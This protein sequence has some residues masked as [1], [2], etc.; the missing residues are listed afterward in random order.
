[1]RTHLASA[2]LT[3]FL[4]TILVTG[5]AEDPA[6]LSPEPTDTTLSEDARVEEVLAEASRWEQFALESDGGAAS[7]VR[8]IAGASR[9]SIVVVPAGSV[10]ALAGALATAGTGGIVV[11]QSGMHTESGT[12]TINTRVHVIGEPGAILQIDTQPFP[13]A[14]FNDPA[15]HVLGAS[16]VLLWG[17]DLRP[18]QGSGN[19]GILLQNASLATIGHSKVT[20]FQ[21]GIVGY[22]SDRA[23][24]YGNVIRAAADG[25]YAVDIV[26]GARV[27]LVSNEIANGPFFGLWAC[28]RDGTA[29]FNEF[30]DNFIGLIFCKV[31]VGD[32]VLPDGQ[33]VG[34]DISATNWVARWNNATNNQWGYLAIDGATGCR[35]VHNDASNNAAYDVEFSGDSERFG[36]FTPTSSNCTVIS[37]DPAIVVKDCGVNNTVIGGTVVD[38]NVDPCF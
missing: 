2:S 11:L 21:I 6:L 29:L 13:A 20:D 22:R 32:V 1:M 15:L 38:T 16:R 35:M 14:G 31:P 10:D 23:F 33:V 19:T 34:S 8:E 17:I 12:V 3:A 25:F 26:S 37:A 4:L 18:A 5:C 24:I 28:D 36:F 30:H 7:L 27:S 9:A